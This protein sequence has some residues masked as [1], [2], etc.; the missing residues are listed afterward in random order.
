M[1]CSR[2]LPKELGSK[3]R[4]IFFCN[5]P[6]CRNFGTYVFLLA[7]ILTVN[8]MAANFNGTGRT[9]SPHQPIF[10]LSACSN[11]SW[12]VSFIPASYVDDAGLLREHTHIGSVLDD[13]E[14][15]VVFVTREDKVCVQCAI[16]CNSEQL[17]VYRR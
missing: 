13:Y 11:L 4:F 5:V 3:E 8:P 9:P 2:R 16:C 6:Y 10:I 12:Y 17:P 7:V 15:K 14:F 1:N